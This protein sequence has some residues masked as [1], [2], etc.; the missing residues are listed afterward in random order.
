MESG[1]RSPEERR[2]AADARARAR[3][4]EPPETGDDELL[5]GAGE[6]GARG[7]MS[8]HYGG[9]DIY[10]RRRLIAGGA[11]ILVIL[12]IFLLVGGC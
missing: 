2:A 6:T 1:G 10:M 3:S 9:P 11:A 5:S 8:R 7:S 4:G 12:L